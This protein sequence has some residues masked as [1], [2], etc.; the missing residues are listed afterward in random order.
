M[1]NYAD[2]AIITTQQG[3]DRAVIMSDKFLCSDDPEQPLIS[4]GRNSHGGCCTQCERVAI[5]RCFGSNV[6]ANRAASTASIF[7]HASSG[8]LMEM[9]VKNSDKICLQNFALVSLL[10]ECECL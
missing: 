2:R 10:V 3:A 4:R 8:K 5:R 7:N 9:I 1:S 6:S